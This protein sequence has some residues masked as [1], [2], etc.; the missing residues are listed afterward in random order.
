MKTILI[1]GATSGIGHALTLL[2]AKQQY[3]VIACG[4]SAEKLEEFLTLPSVKTLIFDVTD[5]QQ[6]LEALSGVKADIYV[7]NAGV[8][9]YVDIEQLDT[10]LFKRVFDANF[11]GIVNCISAINKKLCPSNQVV[12]VDSMARLLPFTRSQAYGA[13]KAAVHYLTKSLE[14]DLAK[15]QVI[16]QSVSPGFVDTPLTQQNDFDMPMQIG[17]ERAA[18]ALLKGIENKHSNIYFPFIFGISLRL[19]NKLPNSWQVWLCKKMKS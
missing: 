19:M 9:E 7:F 6:T 14:V 3:Q 1:T 16:I 10:A 4:R 2:A 5:E 8:C 11:F 17:V 15:K 18:K 12:I 13:S